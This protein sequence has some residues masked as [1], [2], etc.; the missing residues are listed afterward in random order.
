MA[1]IAGIC[2]TFGVAMA[3]PSPTE[4]NLDKAIVLMG[5][6]VEEADKG[7]FVLGEP[8]AVCPGHKPELIGNR[9]G[10]EVPA[11]SCR[12]F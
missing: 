6:A 3:E 8:Y 4:K 12:C 5:K 10:C 11:F 1:M 7:N 2:I 9:N